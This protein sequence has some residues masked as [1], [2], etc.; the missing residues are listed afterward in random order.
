MESMQF[1]MVMAS[2]AVIFHCPRLVF[3][4]YSGFFNPLPIAFF[5][6]QQPVQI[7]SSIT[8]LIFNYSKIKNVYYHFGTIVMHDI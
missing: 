1:S 3:Y 5:E 7:I 6:L 4:P 2:R 8:I